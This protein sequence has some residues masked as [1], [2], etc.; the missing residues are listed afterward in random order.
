MNT[1]PKTARGRHT[2][3]FANYK[4]EEKK[5]KKVDKTRSS[6]SYLIIRIKSFSWLTDSLIRCILVRI[7]FCGYFGACAAWDFPFWIHTRKV[8]ENTTNETTY[9]SVFAGESPLVLT[10]RKTKMFA[11]GHARYIRKGHKTT[12]AQETA[13]KIFVCIYLFFFSPTKM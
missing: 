13:I 7:K 2:S 1:K 4:R 3:S 5:K 12:T 11:G 6:S 8:K 9:F 10:K